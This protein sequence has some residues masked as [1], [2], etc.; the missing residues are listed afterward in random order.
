MAKTIKNTENNEHE[1]A[2]S[3]IQACLELKITG[4]YKGFVLKK[5]KNKAYSLHVWKEKLKKDGLEF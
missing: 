4:Y 5:Y 3:N 2:L 1:N